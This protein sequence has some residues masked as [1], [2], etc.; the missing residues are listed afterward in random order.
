MYSQV[1]NVF[2][3]IREDETINRMPRTIRAITSSILEMAE[4]YVPDRR[5][6]LMAGYLFLRL[7]NPCLSSPAS[8]GMVDGDFQISATS[9]QRMLHISKA[10]Q[11]LS[12][13]TQ[14]K[15]NPRFLR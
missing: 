7:Y 15:D 11:H 10:L 4:R 3:C 6:A 1:V 8:F 13:N 14:P 2:S 12:N 5:Y 9:R